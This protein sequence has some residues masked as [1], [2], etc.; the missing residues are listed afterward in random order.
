MTD[1]SQLDLLSWYP[2]GDTI[3]IPRDGPRLGAQLQ[4]VYDFMK[5]TEGWTTL[6]SIAAATGAP[7]ASASARLR[8]L[9]R[10]GFEIERRYIVNGLHEYRMRRAGG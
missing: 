2:K 7:E 8:D 9:K 10:L 1:L 4:R 5:A 6:R 3:D